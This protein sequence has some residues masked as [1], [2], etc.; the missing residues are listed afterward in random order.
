MSERGHALAPHKAAS[1]WCELQHSHNWLWLLQDFASF[2]EAR[3]GARA[4]TSNP[5]AGEVVSSSRLA[6]QERL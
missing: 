5:M 3:G 2:V 6:Q 1:I 4:Y